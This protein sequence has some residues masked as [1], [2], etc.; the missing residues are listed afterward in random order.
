MNM[1]QL[2]YDQREKCNKIEQSMMFMRLTETDLERSR[3]YLATFESPEKCKA[4]VDSYNELLDL[5]DLL[6]FEN[7]ELTEYK[8]MY[9]DLCD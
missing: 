9:E 8:H 5:I 3:E 4:F 7:K 6:K 1:N 2:I